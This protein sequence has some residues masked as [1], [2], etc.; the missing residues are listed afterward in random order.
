MPQTAQLEGK[1]GDNY[2]GKVVMGTNIKPERVRIDGNGNVIDPK[3]KQIIK[4]AEKEY[5]P[6]PED[7][8]RGTVVP[9]PNEIIDPPPR[10]NS[11]AEIKERI[12]V[13]E[14]HLTELKALKDQKVA[15][16]KKEL[17]EAEKE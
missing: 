13:V 16:M 14:A 2:M 7:L 17:E 5:Q 8:S 4:P 10:F 6:T 15:E 1:S 3:T 11:L 12:K 9:P